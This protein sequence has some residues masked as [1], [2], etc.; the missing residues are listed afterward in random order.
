PEQ[1]L[2]LAEDLLHRRNAGAPRQV[3]LRRASS[4]AYYALFHAICL[5]AANRFG[6]WGQPSWELVYRS[7]D[8]SAVR[9]QCQAA[10]AEDGNPLAEFAR[11]VAELQGLRHKSDYDPLF[12]LSRSQCE[13]A[14]ATAKAALGMWNGAGI[15]AQ[16]ALLAR[17]SFKQR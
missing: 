9:K 15:E 16:R 4:T 10:A 1:L 17:I 12:K 3:V 14:V 13:R 5:A 2:E 8:H 7:V 6:Q 11:T